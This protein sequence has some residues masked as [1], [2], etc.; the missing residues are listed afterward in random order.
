[1]T[2]ETLIDP[3]A[4]I[5]VTPAIQRSVWAM[6]TQVPG[7][8]PD[9]IDIAPAT[10]E[11][12][13]MIGVTLTGWSP[14]LNTCKIQF[15]GRRDP[16]APTLGHAILDM[17]RPF[18]AA[19]AMRASDALDHGIGM[20]V[21]TTTIARPAHSHLAADATHLAMAIRNE[22]T[23]VMQNTSWSDGREGGDDPMDDTTIV[24]EVVRTAISTVSLSHGGNSGPYDG[25]TVIASSGCVA[26]ERTGPG[27]STMRC[28]GM[29]SQSMPTADDRILIGNAASG[30]TRATMPRAGLPDSAVALLTGRRFDDVFEMPPVLAQ[31]LGPRTMGEVTERGED[32]FIT[33]T[34]LD[35]AFTDV[36]G[37]TPAQAL[38]HL[39]RMIRE[40]R[41]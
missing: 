3:L 12:E 2:I 28:V 32:L 8:V 17:L 27:G 11:A 38:L 16:S 1:M 9:A 5:A 10:D 40:A 26:M 24:D 29:A 6:C 13:E 19:Q 21:E 31:Y 36:V 25:G 30:S 37:K 14:T 39:T 34:P 33:L 20:P 35:A 41:A 7:L 18:I 4:R 23:R 15:A 22:V